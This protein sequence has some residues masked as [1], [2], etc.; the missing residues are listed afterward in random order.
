MSTEEATGDENY[1]VEEEFS[2]WKKN[3]PFLYDLVISHSLEWPSLTVQW[4]PSPPSLYSD[5]S[6]AV[7]KLILGTHTSD[8][9]PN[10]LLVAEAHLPVNSSS[11]L[12]TDLENHK[13]PKVSRLICVINVFF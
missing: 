12:E 11:A 6:F 2:V 5:G 8:D 1:Q 10:F 7:H 9:C 4:L 13:I 3:T